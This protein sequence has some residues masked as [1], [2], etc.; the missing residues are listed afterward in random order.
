VCAAHFH[1]Q[2]ELPQL[3]AAHR[4]AVSIG[5]RLLDPLSEYIKIEISSIGVG[6]YQK[7]VKA[8]ALKKMADDVVESCV[9]YAGA[10]ELL[11]IKPLL[12]LLCSLTAVLSF[13]LTSCTALLTGADVNTA[14]ALLLQHI[15]GIGAKLAERIVAE[16]ESKGA[17]TGREQLKKRAKLSARVFEQVKNR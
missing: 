17:Y 3:E 1:S 9:H 5:R 12:E 4:G 2:T 10:S 14:S 16:R 6:M 13:V 7:D 15:G 8:A 11:F